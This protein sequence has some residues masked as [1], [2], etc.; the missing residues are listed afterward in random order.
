VLD[1]VS[2]REDGC[3]GFIFEMGGFQCQI[4]KKRKEKKRNKK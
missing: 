1:Y 2:W 4:E 3:L